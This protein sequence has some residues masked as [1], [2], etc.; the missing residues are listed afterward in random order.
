MATN[1]IFR[2]TPIARGS[3]SNADVISQESLP[4]N[5]LALLD[6]VLVLVNTTADGFVD[7]GWNHY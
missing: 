3:R 5:S 2:L 1:I 4:A 7:I 6:N